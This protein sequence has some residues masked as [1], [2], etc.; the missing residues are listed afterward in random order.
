ME[1]LNLQVIRFTDASESSLDSEMAEMAQS[2][3]VNT[4]V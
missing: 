4:T 2:L 3:V 1:Q